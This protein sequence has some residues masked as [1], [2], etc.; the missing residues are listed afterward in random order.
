LYKHECYTRRV[1]PTQMATYS[2]SGR[3]THAVTSG[4]GS[5]HVHVD[6]LPY[7][8]GE[9]TANPPN[10]YHVGYVRAGDG[11]AWWEPSLIQAVDAWIGIPNGSTILG[12]SVADG[13]A[14]TITEVAGSYPLASSASSAAFT[15]FS[16][17]SETNTQVTASNNSQTCHSRTLTSLTA[18]TYLVACWA[19]IQTA[20]SGSLSLRVGGSNL[21]WGSGTDLP[22]HN[23]AG[24]RLL[25]GRYVHTGGTAVIT[26]V[27]TAESSSNVVV[28]VGTDTRFGR[29]LTVVRVG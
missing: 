16:D 27:V 19:W 14:I 15:P 1:A 2:V 24:E 12:Y 21:M 10:L 20:N 8:A 25:I 6:T 4:T 7:S 17:Y 18:G 5:L 22:T 13:G 23:V 11:T 9:G 3:G 29:K 28:G 26:L